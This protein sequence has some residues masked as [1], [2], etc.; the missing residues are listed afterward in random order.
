MKKGAIKTDAFG[1][2]DGEREEENAK[3]DE[4]DG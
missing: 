4:M 1:E 3:S 2:Q